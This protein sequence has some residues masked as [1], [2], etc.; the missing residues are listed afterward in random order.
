MRIT[1]DICG[2]RP[3][4]VQDIQALHI[5]YRL[6][7]I[8]IGMIGLLLT[9]FDQTLEAGVYTLTLAIFALPVLEFILAMNKTPKNHEPTKVL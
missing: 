9:N 4:P 3:N 5:T 6:S 1:K 8:L 7:I 2:T